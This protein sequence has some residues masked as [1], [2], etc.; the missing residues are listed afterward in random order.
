MREAEQQEATVAKPPVEPQEQEVV[1]Q[2]AQH[3][4]MVQGVTARQILVAA[5]VVVVVSQPLITVVQVVQA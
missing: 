1:E 3:Q 4:E 2:V 5:A